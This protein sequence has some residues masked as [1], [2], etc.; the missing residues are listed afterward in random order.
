MDYP[1]PSMHR[2]LH[3]IRHFRH[4]LHC[5]QPLYPPQSLKRLL[6]RTKTPFVHQRQTAE[7]HQMVANQ[8]AYW[9]TLDA[10][11]YS[12]LTTWTHDQR[13]PIY[14]H[15]ELLVDTLFIRYRM[16]TPVG[17]HTLSSHLKHLRDFIFHGRLDDAKI[18]IISDSFEVFL[19]FSTP[20]AIMLLPQPS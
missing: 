6:P 16:D 4:R 20:Q 2:K 15:S 12:L 8:L 9:S 10:G 19:K 3:G 18:A 1:E 17:P 11:D 7:Q 13:S 14:H 5:P